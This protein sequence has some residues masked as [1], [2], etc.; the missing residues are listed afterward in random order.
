M[1]RIGPWSNILRIVISWY[2]DDGTLKI[3]TNLS[4]TQMKLF[5]HSFYPEKGLLVAYCRRQGIV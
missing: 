4:F 1:L 5:S 3:A 2:H